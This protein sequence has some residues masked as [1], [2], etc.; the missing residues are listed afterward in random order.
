LIRK[1]WEMDP[2]A[3]FVVNRDGNTPFDC[4][5]A[6][7]ND[8][9]I[10]Y[11]QWKLSVEQIQAAIEKDHTRQQGREKLRGVAESECKRVLLLKLPR[12]CVNIVH[13][14]LFTRIRAPL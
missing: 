8:W 6:L 12:D 3:L 10:E 4:A 1:A 7:A 11:F 14:Y 13:D 5:V 9:A 2:E